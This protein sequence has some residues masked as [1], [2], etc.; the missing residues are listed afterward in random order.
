MSH[1]NPT[2]PSIDV[3][4]AERRLRDGPEMPLVV[5]VREPNEFGV[6]RIEGAALVP[7][8]QFAVRYAELPTDRPLF[9]VC[10]AGSRSLAATAHLLRNGWADVVNV[11]GGLDAWQRAG[12]PV[13]RGAIAPGEGQLPG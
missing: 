13:R 8:S 3:V 2:I 12:F 1:P 10:A 9:I 4:E 6:V 11:T 7:L 5:D